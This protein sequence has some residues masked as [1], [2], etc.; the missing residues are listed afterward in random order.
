MFHGL[1]QAGEKAFGRKASNVF[2]TKKTKN[3]CDPTLT[4]DQRARGA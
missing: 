2:M 3:A 4:K 1:Y